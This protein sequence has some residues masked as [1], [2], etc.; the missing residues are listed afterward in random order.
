V[1]AKPPILVSP[2]PRKPLKLYISDAD[3]PIRCLLAQDAEDGIERSIY[4]FIQLLNNA[5]CKYT[6]ME[7]LFLSL[8]YACTKLEC[9]ILLNEIL[10]L[11]KFDIVKNLL[12]QPIL[13][14]L[15]IKWEN[16]VKCL[17]FY[18]CTITGYERASVS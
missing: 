2:I 11:C 16:K 17:C 8:F 1:L 4:Y 12:N 13:Q 15:M 9:Y 3:K 6:P 14:G 10:V 18:I 7:K 5:K